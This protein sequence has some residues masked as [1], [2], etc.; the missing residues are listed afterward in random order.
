MLY[1]MSRLGAGGEAAHSCPGSHGSCWREAG[2]MVCPP[3]IHCAAVWRYHNQG[4]GWRGDVSGERLR[5]GLAVLSSAL[6]PRGA[7]QHPYN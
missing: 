6:S 2:P 1:V 5:A 4:Q 7:A 3:G